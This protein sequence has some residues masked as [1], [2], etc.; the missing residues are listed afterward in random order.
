MRKGKEK[1]GMGLKP[2]TAR[3][4]SNSKEDISFI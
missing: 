1:G 2:C 3:Q 4:I